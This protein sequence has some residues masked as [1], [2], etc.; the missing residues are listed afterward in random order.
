MREE[1]NSAAATH[2]SASSAVCGPDTPWPSKRQPTALTISLTVSLCLLSTRFKCSWVSGFPSMFAGPG[3]VMSWTTLS[4]LDMSLRLASIFAS[5]VRKVLAASMLMS[6]ARPAQSSSFDDGSWM[7]RARNLAASAHTST[8]AL[9]D[10]SEI[11]VTVAKRHP[12]PRRRLH[13]SRTIAS[14][15]AL[16]LRS[17]RFSSGCVICRFP[18]TPSGPGLVM[19]RTTLSRL[20][21]SKEAASISASTSRIASA[22]AELM[23]GLRPGIS[24]GRPCKRAERNLAAFAHP[25]ASSVVDAPDVSLP[26]RRQHTADNA[27]RTYGVLSRSNRFKG[28]C[29]SGF[30]SMFFG[31]GLVISW[32]TL[33]K[34]AINLQ[35]AFILACSESSTSS[36]GMGV[37]DKQLKRPFRHCMVGLRLTRVIEAGGL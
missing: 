4:W 12:F 9:S 10:G 15:S 16:S 30:P 13:T 32:T 26:S 33:S 17:T 21:I 35:A 2:T 31:P 34:F 19:S 6:G 1:R 8:S 23:S 3:L 37:S 14:T 7:R 25:S 36:R 24:S 28:S 27:A 5:I 11:A 22:E 29:V 18:L 20:N